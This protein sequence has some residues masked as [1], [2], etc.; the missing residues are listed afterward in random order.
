MFLTLLYVA[1]GGALGA[2]MRFLT[3]AY[4]VRLLGM[5]FPWGTLSVNVVGSF[6]MGLLFVLLAGR[7]SSVMAPFLMIGVLGGF[8]TFSAFSLDT[9]RLFEAGQLGSAALYVALSMVMSL[10]AV[11]LGVWCAKG[12]FA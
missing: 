11:A 12:G 3:Q 1:L 9:L 6:V 8:T 4:A 2:V 10:S 5:S 7:D